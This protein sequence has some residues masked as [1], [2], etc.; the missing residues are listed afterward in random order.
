MADLARCAP[1]GAKFCILQGAITK[2]LLPEEIIGLQALAGG[3][4]D[5]IAVPLRSSPVEQAAR[6]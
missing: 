5:P 6:L 1:N 4:F 3:S 2:G